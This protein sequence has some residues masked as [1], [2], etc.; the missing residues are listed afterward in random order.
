MFI[1]I[2]LQ[3]LQ[4]GKYSIYHPSDAMARCGDWFRTPWRHLSNAVK[5]SYQPMQ[6]PS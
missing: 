4:N 2:I 5:V 6:Q 1:A 3:R